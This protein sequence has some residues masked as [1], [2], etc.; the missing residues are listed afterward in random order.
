MAT[1]EDI[2]GLLMAVWG[3]NDDARQFLADALEENGDPRARVVRFQ[4][5]MINPHRWLVIIDPV[6][7]SAIQ[8]PDKEYIKERVFALFPEFVVLVPQ[9]VWNH[10]CE[11]C[12]DADGTV[13]AV[14][15]MTSYHW[16]GEG[17]DPNRDRQL[18]S[19]CA[20]EH[21]E[22][23]TDQWEEYRSTRG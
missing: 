22:W 13:T 17:E 4:H 21:V 3:G 10:A 12:G 15:S 11:H 5:K 16:E 14:D 8:I 23:W 6:A 2:T 7:R 20:E 9:L 19:K 18:C 1:R